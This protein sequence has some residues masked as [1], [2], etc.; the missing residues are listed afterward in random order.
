MKKDANLLINVPDEGIAGVICGMLEN[1]GIARRVVVP[2][3]GAIYGAASLFGVQIYVKPEDY[4]RAKEIV[5][6]CREEA[7][8]LL[9]EVFLEEE[10]IEAE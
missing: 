9:E 2:G 6:S 8:V 5:D 3:A 10:T 7:A 1:E 4:T